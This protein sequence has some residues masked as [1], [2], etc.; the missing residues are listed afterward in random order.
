MKKILLI[1]DSIRAGYDKY[2]KM[3]FEDVA[4][5]GYPAENCRFTTYIIRN[6]LAW[7]EQALGNEKIDLVHINV[8][9]WDTLRMHD[10]EVL[11]DKESYEKNLDRIFCLLARYMPEAKVIFATSTPVN[12]AGFG[13]L[14]RFN[15][16]IEA[17]N[18]V[19]C[20]LAEKH[21][22]SV[23]D[24]YTLLKDVPLSYHSD[25]TH[26]Y[27]KDATKII[28]ERVVACIETELGIKGKPLDYDALFGEKKDIV[29]I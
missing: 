8:G 24:L 6:L 26:F 12:E 15:K 19:A 18:A 22:A 20:A 29:G 9:L 25:M 4:E 28:T 23:N 7:K 2:V 5:V 14:K 16:D 21:G 13:D 1:G 10:G 11:V 17:Y 3:A 27:T